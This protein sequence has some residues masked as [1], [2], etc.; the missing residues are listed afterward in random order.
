MLIGR[1]SVILS[2]AAAAAGY[3]TR[4]AQATQAD[5]ALPDGSSRWAALDQQARFG[6]AYYNA[7][8]FQARTGRGAAQA[9]LVSSSPND[10]LL[11]ADDMATVTSA[12]QRAIAG[13]RGVSSC[14]TTEV[15]PNLAPPWNSDGGPTLV[16]GDAWTVYGYNCTLQGSGVSQAWFAYQTTDASAAVQAAFSALPEVATCTKAPRPTVTPASIQPLQQ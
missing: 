3:P 15:N 7:S 16:F 8:V 4:R 10:R 14:Q 12:I 11:S 6:L 9:F 13:L 2:G 1:R 5:F